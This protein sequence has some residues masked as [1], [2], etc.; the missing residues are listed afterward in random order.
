MDDESKASLRGSNGLGPARFL[1]YLSLTLWGVSLAL[2]V[3]F[4]NNWFALGGLAG[5]VVGTLYFA[6]RTDDDR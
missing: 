5:F 4:Q 2:F 1:R 6:I 3:V